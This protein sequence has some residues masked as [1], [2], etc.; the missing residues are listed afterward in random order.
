[1]Q[2]VFFFFVCICLAYA[3]LADFGHYPK[4]YDESVCQELESYVNRSLDVNRGLIL[5]RLVPDAKY[6]GDVGSQYFAWYDDRP[7]PTPA[8]FE[9]EW[10]IFLGEIFFLIGENCVEKKTEYNR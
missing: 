6:Y 4:K 5:D 2:S 8:E 10:D 3:F 1:M 9:A 7:F